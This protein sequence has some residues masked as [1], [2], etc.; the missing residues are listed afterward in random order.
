MAIAG[1]RVTVRMAGTPTIFTDA[2]TTDLGSNRFQVTDSSKRVFSTEHAVTVKD[3]ATTL[4][5]ADYAVDYLFGVVTL[6]D[7]PSGA[8]TV[9]ARYL[10]LYT[11]AEARSLEVNESAA[12]LDTSINGEEYTRLITGKFSA[13]VSMDVLR[14]ASEYVDV[15]EDTETVWRD[16]Y[17]DRLP[18]LVE[19]DW[20]GT[21]KFR[22]WGV[23][24]ALPQSAPQDGV[25]SGARE[26][27]SIIRPALGRT[28]AVSFGDGT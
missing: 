8:V 28:E 3:G 10:P 11:V 27:K 4:D 14:L 13:T 9:S 22:M 12:E 19:V 16:I 6:N 23:L 24:P 20:D 18:K 17:S 2:A 1:F 15:A 5:A 7:A 26:F 25:I 21:H